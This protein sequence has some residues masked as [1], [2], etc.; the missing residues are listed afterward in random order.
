MDLTRE[1]CRSVV[2]TAPPVFDSS[3]IQ[4]GLGGCPWR[5]AVA[6]IL[7]CRTRRCQMQGVLATLFAKWPTPGDLARADESTLEALVRPCGLHR[8][9]ARQLIRF[10]NRWLGDAWTD[11]RDLPG[12]GTYV[13]DAVSIFCFGAR[14][15]DGAD[16]VLETYLEGL[17]CLET[18]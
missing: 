8:T 15:M 14:T 9:R 5:V 11:M 3:P 18:T 13:A 12:V 7:L 17:H 16:G 4:A 2:V 10:S 1:R 6:S